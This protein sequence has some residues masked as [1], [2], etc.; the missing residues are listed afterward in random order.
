MPALAFTNLFTSPAPG[1]VPAT[2]QNPR[3]RLVNTDPQR[4]LR[5]A[6]EPVADLILRDARTPDDVDGNIAQFLDSP[7]FKVWMDR[8]EEKMSEAQANPVNVDAAAAE[9]LMTP[10]VGARVAKATTAPGPLQVAV[11][12][13]TRRLNTEATIGKAPP[14][15]L[16]LWNVP[17]SGL[18]QLPPKLA[19][20]LLENWA[21][22]VAGIVL[23]HALLA[24][25]PIAPA[26]AEH[27]FFDVVL[28]GKKALLGFLAS[29][30]YEIP[31]EVVPANERFE[32]GREFVSHAERM[33]KIRSAPSYDPAELT[34]HKFFSDGWPTVRWSS[35][36]AST[37]RPTRLDLESF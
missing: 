6:A 26:L 14:P 12:A 25:A 22:K 31:T 4:E 18:S 1:A 29:L 15:G 37:C 27:L 3:P 10:F 35:A 11:D 16:E 7:S 8:F 2:R 23:I 34:L 19:M 30:G 32:L 13:A 17:P 5:D 28:A 9:A 21:S 33:N 20:L 36:S 24:N